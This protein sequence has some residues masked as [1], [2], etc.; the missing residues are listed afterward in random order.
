M[1]MSGNME[2]LNLNVEEEAKGMM[3]FDA[4]PEGDYDVVVTEAAMVNNKSSEGAH[5]AVTMQV[6]EGDFTGRLIWANYNVS[7]PNATAE[8][9]GRSEL[10]ALCRAMGVANPQDTSELKDKPFKVKLGFEKNKEKDAKGNPMPPT[11][12]K[13]KAYMEADGPSGPKEEPKK[14]EAPREAPKATTA[15]DKKTPPWKRK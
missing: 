3:S 10:A 1:S 11:K 13:V 8:K 4:L 6:I 5:I 12:N 9:I 2:A 7:N 15:T 14:E